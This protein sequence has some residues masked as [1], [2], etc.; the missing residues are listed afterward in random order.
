MC[1]VLFP[2]SQK[3][4]MADL[5]G[6]R[7]TAQKAWRGEGSKTDQSEEKNEQMADDISAK[8]S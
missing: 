4:N 5:Y 7:E 1:C 2:Y 3:L 6:N 8:S